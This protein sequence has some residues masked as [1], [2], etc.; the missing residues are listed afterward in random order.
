[1]ARGDGGLGKADPWPTNDAPFSLDDDPSPHYRDGYHNRAPGGAHTQAPTDFWLDGV[2]YP[3]RPDV[4]DSRASDI[5]DFR[6]RQFV[7]S[8]G[9][10]TGKKVGP[11]TD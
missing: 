10:R 7:V 9:N 3:D 1:M 6:D 11:S 2:V 4:L 8:V 5:A